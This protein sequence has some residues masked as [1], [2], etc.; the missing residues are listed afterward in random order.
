MGFLAGKKALIIG[1]AS[2][3]SIAYGIAK[4]FHE[5]GAELAFT[6]QGERLKERVESMAAEFNSTLTFPC[7]VA[8]DAEIT[9][10]FVNLGKHWNKFDI[11]IHSV[12]YAPADQISGDFVTSCTREGFRIAHDISAYS[13]IGLAQAALPMMEETQG[14]ILTMSYYGA[15]KAVPN[16]NVMGIA[17]ASLEASVRYLASSLGSRG[18]RVNAIS[19]GP[20]KTLAAAGIK[21]FRKIQTAYASITPLQRNVT[22]EEVGNTAAFL[23][24]NLA[25]GI[26]GE[27]VHVDAG[28]HAVSTMSDLT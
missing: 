4:A 9:A 22:I 2:N 3:R 25:S 11:L 12:A 6:Y 5:Q 10:L 1:L 14:S 23:C 24:S 21:D 18:L 26:T 28:Y 7:D 8:N 27:V 19:A 17:K 16:Y 13:L 20:I 15:E